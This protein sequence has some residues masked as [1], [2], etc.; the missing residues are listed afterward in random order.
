MKELKEAIYDY[1][2]VV[3]RDPNNE[4]IWRILTEELLNA[5]LYDEAIEGNYNPS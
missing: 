3:E 4:N 5:K 2:M 1:K